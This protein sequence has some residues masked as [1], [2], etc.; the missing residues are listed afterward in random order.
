MTNRHISGIAA[1]GVAALAAT[2][3]GGCTA[4]NS[5][6][7][8]AAPAA[9]APV[10]PAY[11]PVLDPGSE[12]VDDATGTATITGGSAQP[13]RLTATKSAP[14]QIAVDAAGHYTVQLAMHGAGG[15]FSL[16]GP[17]AVGSV[18]GDKVSVVEPSSG[19]YVDTATQ[20][21]TCTVAYT[22]VSEARVAGTTACPAEINGK[23]LN[24]RVVFS[25]IPMRAHVTHG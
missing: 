21:S 4:S 15:V 9:K 3:L 13:V 16:A 14:S 10:A 22:T 12:G 24:I 8:V 1:A 19:L 5:H 18:S 7:V 2:A 17:A 23:R 11:A 25:V 6:H 20:G